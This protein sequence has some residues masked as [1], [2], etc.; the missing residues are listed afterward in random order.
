M[1]V[2]GTEAANAPSEDST[3]DEA[4]NVRVDTP[5]SGVG[6]KIPSA[7]GAV[8]TV[9]GPGRWRAAGPFAA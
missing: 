6:V 3:D 4:P 5:S 2:E 1:R 7:S 9:P 8:S